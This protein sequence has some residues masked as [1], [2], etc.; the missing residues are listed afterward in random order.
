MTIGSL[1]GLALLEV[2]GDLYRNIVS[3]RVSQDLFDD[4]SDDPADWQAAIELE[5]A[6]KPL[7]YES[8]QP[9]I[10]RPF[11]DAEFI[12]A[13]RFPFDNWSQSRFSRGQFGVWYGSPELETTIFETAYHWRNGLLADAGLENREG[14]S[15]E[16]R[17]HL[18]HCR[19]ALINLL[20]KAAEWPELRA[21]DYAPCQSLGERVHREGHPGLWAPSARCDGTNAAVFTPRV[22]SN[23]RPHCYLTY[24]IEGGA[25]KVWRD[26]ETALMAI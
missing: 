17:V 4:L 3:L 26:P 18:V 5:A 22:L 12:S 10:D 13:V 2:D 21:D 11:E 9:V 14:V 7:Q 15:I 19:S 6:C 1:G 23:P 20:P 24:R 8:R 25:V 16:R